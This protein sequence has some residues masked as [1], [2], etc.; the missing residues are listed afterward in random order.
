M[1][2]DLIGHLRMVDHLSRP[3]RSATSNIINFGSKLT[4]ITAGVGA[5]TGVAGGAAGAVKLLN[6]TIGAAAKS[7]MAT[8]NM[9]A[10]FKGNEVA[11]KGFY[12]YI[13]KKGAESVL[14]DDDFMAAS[15]T[16]AIMTKDIGELK[17]LVDIGERLAVMDP[18]QGIEGAAV[19]LRELSGGDIV[20]L[21]ERFEMPKKVLNQIKNLPLKKQLAALDNELTKYGVTQEMI[22]SQGQTALGLYNKTVDKTRVAFRN[23]GFGALEELKPMLR[24]INVWLDRNSAAITRFGSGIL[25]DVAG[26]FRTAFDY[27]RVNYLENEAFM[28]L[29]FADKITVVLDDMKKRWDTWYDTTGKT[30]IASTTQGLIDTMISTAGSEGNLTK[31][32][33]IGMDIGR[34]IGGGALQGLNAVIE[35]H[36]LLSG[37]AVGVVTPGPVPLKAA[38]AAITAAEGVTRPAQRSANDWVKSVW[39]KFPSIPFVGQ[40]KAQFPDGKTGM[41]GFFAKANKH[42]ES[43]GLSRVPYNGYPAIL[44]RDE[45]VLP[46]AAARDYRNGGGSSGPVNVTGNTFIVRKDTDINEIATELYRM[47]KGADNAMGGAY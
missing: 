2:F 10:L 18:A 35:D 46:R 34:A 26:G 45:A 14:S 27:I 36:P 30:M 12:D 21:A 29:P 40:D 19:A 38:T 37:L 3:L 28:K 41:D 7:E 32:S 1:S 44:H 17:G 39:D 22:F 16:F 24:D 15:R 42:K 25:K 33:D 5:L 9:T 43:G 20:S 4:K 47:I 8:M 6:S 23:M 31:L 11:A 13:Q